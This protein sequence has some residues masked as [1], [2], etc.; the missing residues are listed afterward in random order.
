MPIFLYRGTQ[1]A[2]VSA[3][4]TSCYLVIF[5]REPRLKSK[6]ANLVCIAILLVILPTNS[7]RAKAGDY[8]R[9]FRTYSTIDGLTQSA[10]NNIGEDAAGYLWLTTARGLNR[11]DGQDFEQFTIA[12]GLPSNNLTALYI[13]ADNTVWVG[14]ARGGISIIRGTRIVATI[15]P[16]SEESTPITDIESIHGR[17]L[18]VAEG[19]GV[20]EVMSD[21]NDYW[22]RNIGANDIGATDLTTVD[23]TLWVTAEIGSYT[24]DLQDTLIL[25]KAFDSIA[26]IHVDHN[27]VV[28]AVDNNNAVHTILNGELTK[29]AEFTGSEKITK[30][31]TTLD[32]TVWAASN[33]QLFSFDANANE[34]INASI[35][36]R[37]FTEFDELQA[38]FVDRENTV[39][40][41]SDSR[42]IRF[43]GDRFRHYRLKV[44]ADAENVWAISEDND[45]RMWFGT[46]SKLIRKNSDNTLTIV[47]ADYGI[48]HAPVRDIVY[49]QLANMWAGIRGKGLYRVN[50]RTLKTQ[51]VSGTKGLE[52]LDVALAPDKSIWFSTFASGVFRY[53]PANKTLENYATPQT[54]TSVFSLDIWEDGCVWYGADEVGLVMLK[55]HS[56]ENFE[57]QVYGSELGLQSALFDQ[58]R[59]FG[60]HQAWV[61]MDEGGLYLFDDGRF[62]NHGKKTPFADQTV[63]IVEVL[64]SG[65]VIAGGEQGLYQFEVGSPLIAHYSHLEGFVGVE[66]NVHA[67]FL[68]SRDN[69]W[70]GT[71][72]GA[73][74]M[75]TGVPMP[76]PKQLTPQIASIETDVNRVEIS[77]GD[78]IDPRERGVL[79]EFAAVSLSKPR[80]IEYSYQLRGMDENWSLPTANQ[81]VRYSSLPP[82]D[83]E[84]V[85]RA[86]TVGG[87]WGNETASRHFTVTPFFWQR[88]DLVL[89]G[90]V[91]L[92]LCI[93]A[94]MV[95]RTRN[96]QRQNS[97]LRAQVSERTRSI[98]TARCRLI[99]SNQKLSREIQERHKSDQAL[100]EVENT[101]RRAFENAPIGMGLLD[102][103]GRIFDANPALETMFWATSSVPE[104]V[105]FSTVID[106]NGRDD[107]T[108]L[109]TELAE[110]K[111][112]RLEENFECI[113]ASGESLQ[114]IVNLS[115]VRSEANEFLYSVLQIQDVTESLRLTDKLEYQASYDEL[116]GLLN[117]RAFEAELA[118]AW[119]R[120]HSGTTLSYLMF[121]DLDQFKVV[122]DTSGHAAGDQLLKRVSDILLENV[123]GDDVV[124]RLGGDEFG[125]M[126]W[127]CPTDVAMRIAEAIRMSI[128]YLRFQWDKEIYRI[129]VSIGGLQIDP[130]VGSTSELQQL[131][132]AACYAAKEAGRNRVHMVDGDKDSAR[133]HQGQVRWI[134]RIREAMD[135]NR[136]AIY[137]QV[138]K[139]L[140]DDAIEDERLEILL[141]LRDPATRKLIPPGAFL[142]A[143]E[144]YGLSVELDEW[145]VRNLLNALFIHHSFQAANRTYWINL[146]GASVGDKRFAQFLVEAV[147]K[148][149]LPPGTINFEITET[150][151]IRSV[152]EAGN[153]MSKLRDMGCQF[154]LDDFG[155]GLSS[156]GYLKKLPVDYLK[157]D[158]MFIR[159]ILSD[160]TD[161]IFVKSIID[162]AH[163]L[164]I[165]TIAEFVEDSKMLEVVK[166]LGAD[167]AQGF[168]IGRPFSLA[169]KFPGNDAKA[170]LTEQLSQQAS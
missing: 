99:E 151:V 85:V 72:D 138:I 108:S 134:Q 126:L 157:I 106:E 90:I 161:R 158:G 168:A 14:D 74:R 21:G 17:V 75:D 127:N 123:R 77:N 110:S 2:A 53:S 146:S 128:D 23:G 149:P 9:P 47:G 154:A 59:L 60:A 54:K 26:L 45:G 88:P 93:R 83:Y 131:A 35:E 116:T 148:S 49:D 163:T 29:L 112:D 16:V 94:A 38:M 19:L 36:I 137:G 145:V 109:Y 153:L 64:R 135:N 92:L 142:P 122:N 20:F 143:A 39:W 22:L 30:L 69:L 147:K 98:E 156:F 70:I 102:S 119:D 51:L 84:F 27:K 18:V 37:K 24:A 162:I 63:Y 67:T 160:K 61:A 34:D 82:G 73:T 5:C 132:D 56:S 124:C 129:G 120:G 104:G 40:I 91:L 118:R 136:F 81:S 150:A 86:R 105:L 139:P 44:D 65:T 28:W 31:A 42:L 7:A 41:A 6:L 76:E 114:A 15:D 169:P 55:R 71:I 111:V 125:I 115:A 48:P 113:N 140:A 167:Y 12:D 121:M 4:I 96:I 130:K 1:K 165:K 164:K 100:V 13:D 103:D 33:N 159:D 101:F 170:L 46:Q 11:Y 57:Q 166:D 107:F 8:E 155:S 117:R 152:T 66:T 32:G 62:I 144:R 3:D 89:T 43:L 133:I 25:G 78:E 68:D 58:L 97:W 10:V 50:T 87:K 52:I 80:G 95:F 141:R 79:I